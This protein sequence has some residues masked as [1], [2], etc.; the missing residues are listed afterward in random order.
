MAY[1]NC[2]AHNSWWQYFVRNTALALSI[3]D[4]IGW[5]EIKK[6]PHLLPS[7]NKKSEKNKKMLMADRDY[8]EEKE[9]EP[10]V[11]IQLGMMDC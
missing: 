1:N 5:I 9:E 6:E 3:R 10:K 11:A 2:L 7:Q 4:T 8:E